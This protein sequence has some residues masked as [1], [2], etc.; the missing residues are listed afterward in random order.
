LNA[1]KEFTQ[2]IRHTPKNTNMCKMC[3]FD[4]FFI[5]TPFSN[6]PYSGQG[7]N[8]NPYFQKQKMCQYYLLEFL[9]AYLTLY[10][11]SRTTYV[12]I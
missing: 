10:V 6:S 4:E 5:F 7:K 3:I 12:R 2:K 9:N 1:K 11:H 8:I